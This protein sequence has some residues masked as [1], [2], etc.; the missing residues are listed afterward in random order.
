[1]SQC[2]IRIQFENPAL[3]FQ[4]MLQNQAGCGTKKKQ[5]LGENRS[6][7]WEQNF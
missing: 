1:M 2:D 4:N 5:L 3:Q 7:F 6:S